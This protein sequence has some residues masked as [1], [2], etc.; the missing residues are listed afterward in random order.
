M[1]LIVKKIIWQIRAKLPIRI[2]E[3][4]IEANYRKIV[5]EIN[6]NLIS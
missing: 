5:L 6:S 2:P 4:Y 1:I 3:N